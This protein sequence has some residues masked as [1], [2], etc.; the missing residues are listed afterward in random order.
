[1]EFEGIYIIGHTCS[2]KTE[3]SIRLAEELNGEIINCDAFYFYKDCE[4]VTAN[5]TK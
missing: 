5:V 2:G 4:V 1:M 3:L